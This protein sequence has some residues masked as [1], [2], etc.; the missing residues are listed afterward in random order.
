MILTKKCVWKGNHQNRRTKSPRVFSLIMILKTVTEMT[1]KIIL[2]LIY[3]WATWNFHTSHFSGSCVQNCVIYLNIFRP[4][5]IL[6]WNNDRYF[7]SWNILLTTL[8]IISEHGMKYTIIS[9]SING[10]SVSLSTSTW[11]KVYEL[12]KSPQDIWFVSMPNHCMNSTKMCLCESLWLSPGET[13][14]S[15]SPLFCV[16]CKG[17]YFGQ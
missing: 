15:P 8:V 12:W 10:Y 9:R 17:K 7:K 4:K 11:S 1:K 3:F 13:S 6:I 2:D 16:V 14:F 5:R